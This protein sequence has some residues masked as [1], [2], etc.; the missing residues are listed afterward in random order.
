MFPVRAA[1]R[2]TSKSFEDQLVKQSVAG[3][4]DNLVYVTFIFLL[5]DL[6]SNVFLHSMEC[7]YPYSVDLPFNLK[8]ACIYLSAPS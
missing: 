5:I 8:T 1:T 4:F 7:Q 2:K 6:L 3:F